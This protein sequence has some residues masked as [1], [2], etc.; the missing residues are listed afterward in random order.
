MAR[1]KKE[2][3]TVDKTELPW[4]LLGMAMHR[5]KSPGIWQSAP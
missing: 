5:L 4:N 2:K 1:M 3:F